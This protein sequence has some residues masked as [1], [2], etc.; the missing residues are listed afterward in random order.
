MNS[1][2]RSVNICK[3][4][5]LIVYFGCTVIKIFGYSLYNTYCEPPLLRKLSRN[6]GVIFSA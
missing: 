2:H 6:M 5:L 4:L 3:N 1:I